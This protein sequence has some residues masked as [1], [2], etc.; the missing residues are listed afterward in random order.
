[1]MMVIEGDA[2]RRWQNASFANSEGREGPI[3]RG[4]VA[5]ALIPAKHCFANSASLD[6]PP[7]RVSS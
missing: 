1:M 5:Y 6:S 2:E 3:L 7:G 4:K